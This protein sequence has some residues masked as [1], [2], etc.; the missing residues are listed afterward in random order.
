MGNRMIAIE[1]A[2]FSSIG[3]RD[4]LIVHEKLILNNNVAAV[5]EME[6][7]RNAK[8]NRNIG[9]KVNL[10]MKRKPIKNNLIHQWR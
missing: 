4:C 3:V 9:N 6:R 7:E 1:D 8:E 10:N 5:H 2:L